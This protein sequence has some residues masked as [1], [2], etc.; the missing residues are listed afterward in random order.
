MNPL[1]PLLFGQSDEMVRVRCL[2]D[3]FA[4]GSFPVLILGERGTGKTELAAYIHQKSGRLGAF[5]EY[6]G[7]GTSEG[8]EMATL[9]GH[10]RGAFTGA[11][12]DNP[13]LIEAAKGGTLFL[14]EIDSASFKTQ[15]S[16][17]RVLENRP[18]RRQ[19][20]VRCRAMDVRFIAASNADINDMVSTGRFRQDLLD[21]FGYFVITVPPLSRRR[22]EIE[23][24]AQ[25]FLRNAAIHMGLP[26]H[27]GFAPEVMALLLAA[28]WKGNVRQL[29]FLCEYL[30]VICAEKEWIEVADL[31]PGLADRRCGPRSC[32]SLDVIQQTINAAGGSREAAA[33]TLGISPRHLYRLLSRNKSSSSKHSA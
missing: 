11:I 1:V 3:R 24:L 10:R 21:R 22:D 18:V 2:C 6:T 26:R 25:Q 29:R 9:F 19:G 27:P 32:H 5:V 23:P 14:D 8:L 15:T 17:L 7:S 16:L 4:E 31:P 30:T 33:R 12:E 20:E 28:P 13:G